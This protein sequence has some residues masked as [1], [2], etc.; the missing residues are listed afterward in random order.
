MA[1]AAAD[2][3]QL[4]QDGEAAWFGLAIPPCSLDH[5]KYS[6]VTGTAVPVFYCNSASMA[7]ISDWACR[8]PVRRAEAIPS[9][10]ICF[11]SPDLSARTRVW[12]AM[13]YPAV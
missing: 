4:Q 3:G 8:L 11:A 5:R 6:S 10:N 1:G 12:A 2:H 13:K 9:C 7:S